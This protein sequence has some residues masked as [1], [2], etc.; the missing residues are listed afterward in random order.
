MAKKISITDFEQADF[1]QLLQMGRK[2]WTKFDKE[3][4]EQLLQQAATLQ[5]Y[6]IV[7]A[8][9][10]Q[11]EGVGFAIFSIRTDYVE[12]AITSPTGYLEGIFVEPEFRKSGVAR[13]FLRLGEAWCKS[14]GCTQMGSD[15]WLTH[16]QSREFHKRLGFWEEE[17]IV[18]FLKDID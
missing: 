7:L 11:H 16:T 3:D 17:E 6:R 9:N 1:T 8:K 14:R 2:L 15:T 5:K 4:L 12:G 18:H 13:E 10:Q